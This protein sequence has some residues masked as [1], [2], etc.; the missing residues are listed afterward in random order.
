MLQLTL[1]GM[2]LP[3]A[4]KGAYRAWRE[5]L[6]V[7][8]SMISGRL[9][10]EIR[11]TVWRVVYQYGY[12][13]DSERRRV[14]ESCRKG[15]AQPIVCAFLPPDRDE[16]IS[17]EFFITSFTEPKFMWSSDGTPVWGDFA[18]ELREVKPSD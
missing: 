3:E 5:D 10:K 7:E 8:V 1:D 6:G 4:R 11:G 18:I 9:V 13:S 14:I 12:F 2:E 16:L 15:R 17:K